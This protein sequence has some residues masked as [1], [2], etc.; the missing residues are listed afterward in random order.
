MEGIKT[1]GSYSTIEEDHVNK[2]QESFSRLGEIEN[3]FYK[4]N[5]INR[6]NGIQSELKMKESVVAKYLGFNEL[7]VKFH[8]F[9]CARKSK[10]KI[11]DKEYLE[12][13][14]C[15]VYSK[16]WRAI[17][18]NATYRIA[19]N[20]KRK[21]VYVALAMWDKFDLEFI[22]YGQDV[23]IG[24]YISNLVTNFISKDKRTYGLSAGISFSR[25]INYHNFDVYAVGIDTNILYNKLIKHKYLKDLSRSRVHNIKELNI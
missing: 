14:N 2:I 5:N 15:S 18:G 22:V 4:K 13:K 6:P 11:F 3:K 9:D 16:S 20:Y 24:T 23:K 21:N 25:F 19:N 17:F 7:N 8:G 1:I 12:V 10:N